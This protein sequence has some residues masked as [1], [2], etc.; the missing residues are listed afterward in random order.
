[1]LSSVWSDDTEDD[2][3]GARSIARL[4]FVEMI[5]LHAEDGERDVMFFEEADVFADVGCA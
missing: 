1:M 2:G 3:D 4:D 5:E